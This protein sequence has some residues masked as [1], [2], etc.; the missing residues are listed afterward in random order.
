MAM[1]RQRA[2]STASQDHDSL[3]PQR[4]LHGGVL[5]SP[6]SGTASAKYSCVVRERR[7]GKQA[8]AK[9]PCSQEG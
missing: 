1:Q 6:G 9:L 2:S 8:A 5:R 4:H 7:L 3:M